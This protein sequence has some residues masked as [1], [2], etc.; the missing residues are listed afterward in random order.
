MSFGGLSLENRLGDLQCVAVCCSV[1]QGVAVFSGVR[2]GNGGGLP[3]EKGFWENE[4]QEGADLLLTAIEFLA[5]CE[6]NFF[7]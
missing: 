4:H 1:L 7:P 3:L 2:T 5:Q 6:L